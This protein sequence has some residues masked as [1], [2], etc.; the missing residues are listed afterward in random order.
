M[1]Y[2]ETSRSFVRSRRWQMRPLRYFP[3]L[4]YVT[5][6]SYRRDCENLPPGSA[7]KETHTPVRNTYLPTKQCYLTKLNRNTTQALSTL[8]YE[9]ND[10]SKQIEQL[11]H[12]VKARMTSYGIGAIQ[13]SCCVI[14]CFL[15]CSTIM[16]DWVRAYGI[17]CTRHAHMQRH[18]TM[19]ASQWQRAAWWAR[20]PTTPSECIVLR[21]ALLKITTCLTGYTRCQMTFEA[22]ANLWRD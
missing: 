8:H 13:S 9:V 12:R 10:E 22:I 5:K 19:W 7:D 15:N 20:L 21:T 3:S 14:L 17:M 18:R 4:A 11:R 2:S 6:S 1:K 16:L